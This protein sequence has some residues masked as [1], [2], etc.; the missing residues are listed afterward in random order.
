MSKHGLGPGIFKGVGSPIGGLIKLV[1]SAVLV[2]SQMAAQNPAPATRAVVTNNPELEQIYK[3]DQA[4]RAG[5]VKPG[6]D[7]AQRDRE[8]LRRTADLIEGGKA[9]TADDYFQAAQVYNHGATPE[10]CLRSHELAV[11]AA[12]KGNRMALFLSAAS[13]DRFLREIGRPQVFGT[14]YTRRDN[15][16]TME[17]FDRSMSDNLRVEFGVPGLKE[18]DARLAERNK[19]AKPN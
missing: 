14:Q 2:T 12:A 13:L 17:P 16:V 19:S 7:A 6:I 4:E 8:R 15:M 3:E 9:Q 1:A 5:G 11:L 18:L 10:D